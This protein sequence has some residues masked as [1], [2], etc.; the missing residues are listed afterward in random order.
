[1][2]IFRKYFFIFL[3]LLTDQRLEIVKQD[4]ISDVNIL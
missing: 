4:K 2:I 3:K 1:M